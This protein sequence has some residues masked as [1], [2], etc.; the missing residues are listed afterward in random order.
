MGGNSIKKAIKI[1]DSFFNYLVQANYLIGNP[2]AVDRRR[3]KRH[4]TG[5]CIIDRY[6]ELD[7]IFSVL[8]TLSDHPTQDEDHQFQVICARYIILLLFYTGRPDI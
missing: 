3:R 1:L 7:E 8:E 5:P 4:Q 2:L 6:L